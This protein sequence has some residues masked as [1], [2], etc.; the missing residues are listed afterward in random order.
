MIT[1]FGPLKALS[2]FINEESLNHIKF[3]DL[4]NDISI[5]NSTVF[6]PQMEIRSSIAPVQLMG[7]HKFDGRY[8]YKVKVPLRNYKRKRTSEEDQALEEM[9]D[10]SIYLYLIL[11]GDLNNNNVY[12]DKLSVKEKIKERWAQEKE[13]I[14]QI[15][16]KGY[17]KQKIEKAKAVEVNE[18]EY[19]DF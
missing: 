14:K 13:E 17:E 4:E 11:K 1:Q 2:K 16:K 7:Y 12:Y 3:S 6:V 5:A 8:E 9:K 18:D 19:L 15:F 10:G